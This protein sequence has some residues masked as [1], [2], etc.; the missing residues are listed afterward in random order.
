[1]LLNVAAGAYK[2]GIRMA[3]QFIMHLEVLFSALDLLQQ[4]YVTSQNQGISFFTIDYYDLIVHSFL[5][6]IRFG[7]QQRS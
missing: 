4:H 7:L 6:Y 2:E 5:L 1:M 3:N